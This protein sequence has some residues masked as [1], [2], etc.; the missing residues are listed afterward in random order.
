M[1]KQDRPGHRGKAKWIQ[2]LVMAGVALVL[3]KVFA[4]VSPPPPVSPTTPE[5]CLASVHADE[6]N[7][8]ILEGSR[9]PG[10]ILYDI[11]PLICRGRKVFDKLTAQGEDIAAGTV[12][13]KVVVEY[14]GEIISTDI[15]E[16]RIDS[17]RFLNELV[18]IFNMSDFTSWNREDENT[19]FTYTARFGR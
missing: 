15:L 11:A 3:I 12:T 9:T 8:Q 6:K 4:P 13:L 5:D 19:V 2:M 18:G 7:L 16:T 14:N 17:R 10:N 1:Q